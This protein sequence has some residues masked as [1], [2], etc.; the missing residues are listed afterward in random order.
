MNQLIFSL[1]CIVVYKII[2]IKVLTLIKHIPRGPQARG[3][4]TKLG[5]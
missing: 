5:K 1:I 3:Y 2:D 4:F